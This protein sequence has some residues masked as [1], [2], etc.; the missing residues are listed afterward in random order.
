[1]A[2]T[3]DHSHRIAEGLRPGPPPLSLRAA[4]R[5]LNWRK[6]KGWRRPAGRSDREQG[7]CRRLVIRRGPADVGERPRTEDLRLRW[8]GADDA[9]R[10][11]GAVPRG[12]QFAEEI[13]VSKRDRDQKDRVNGETDEGQPSLL[14]AI[15]RRAN[16]THYS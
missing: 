6:L 9:G 14:L 13:V 7:T 8:I 11:G 10:A 4:G 1:M 15:E 16:S 3:C 12:F 5:M 2:A